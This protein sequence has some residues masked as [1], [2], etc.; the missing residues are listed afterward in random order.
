MLAVDYYLF[1]NLLTLYRQSTGYSCQPRVS[2]WRAG[3]TRLSCFAL[4][5]LYNR[6]QH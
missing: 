2:F 3:T 4:Y 5:P 1:I 6:A